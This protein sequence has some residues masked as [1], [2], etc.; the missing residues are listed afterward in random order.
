MRSAKLRCVPRRYDAQREVASRSYDAERDVTSHRATHREARL[1][2]VKRDFA[3]RVRKES[4]A[5]RMRP[6]ENGSV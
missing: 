3:K 2:I 5:L 1:R 4:W 6:E